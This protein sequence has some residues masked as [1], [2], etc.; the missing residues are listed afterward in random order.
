MDEDVF[1]DT[2]GLHQNT[3]FEDVKD[4]LSKVLNP[5]NA[6][7]VSLDDSMDEMAIGDYKKPEPKI[8][9]QPQTPKRDLLEK[10]PLKTSFTDPT[11]NLDAPDMKIDAEYK[12][13]Y[14]NSNIIDQ[15]QSSLLKQSVES[16]RGLSKFAKRGL[17]AL[18]ADEIASK[19]DVPKPLTQDE[20]DFIVGYSTKNRV[21]DKVDMQDIKNDWVNG[22]YATATLK[23]L[24]EMPSI[25]ADSSGEIAQL[26]NL[27]STALA[28]SARVSKYE[29]EYVKNN[30]GKLPDA[31]W[32]AEAVASQ[33]IILLAERFGI[34]KLAKTLKSTKP[35]TA[36]GV[37]GGIVGAGGF[38]GVQEY[39]ENV[40]EGYLTQKDGAKTLG[41]LATSDDAKFSAFLGTVMGGSMKGTAELGSVAYK[42]INS[43]NQAD[44]REKFV[45]AYTQDAYNRELL[46]GGIVSTVDDN[47]YVEFKKGIDAKVKKIQDEFR[48]L[49]I[50]HPEH[51]VPVEATENIAVQEMVVL[52]AKE[53]GLN[54]SDNNGLNVIDTGFKDL[55]DELYGDADALPEPKGFVDTPATDEIV[56]K[57]DEPLLAQ[58]EVVAPEIDIQRIKEL[59]SIPDDEMTI[60]EQF[61]LE[62]LKEDS[63]IA[64][65]QDTVSEIEAINPKEEYSFDEKI[66]ATGSIEDAV[67]VWNEIY[68]SDISQIDKQNYLDI[69]S[70][71][72]NWGKQFLKKI[73]Q[74]KKP[75]KKDVLG[76][77]A[78]AP[79]IEEA[80]APT[81]EPISKSEKIDDTNN[82]TNN[83]TIKMYLK[84]IE[85]NPDNATYQEH[86]A[87]EIAYYK[88]LEDK[89]KDEVDFS[90][91]K[92]DYDNTVQNHLLEKLDNARVKNKTVDSQ[93]YKPTQEEI[94]IVAAME[95]DIGMTIQLKKDGYTL[96][97][98][99]SNKDERALENTTNNIDN[100]PKAPTIEEAKAKALG[101]K[102]GA[103]STVQEQ[104][105]LN[106]KMYGDDET[107]LKEANARIFAKN[108]SDE[109]KIKNMSKA[110]IAELERE[111]F[112]NRY[113]ETE[114]SRA[115]DFLSTNTKQ[116]SAQQGS[117][118]F[119]GTQQQLFDTQG[120]EEYVVPQWAKPLVSDTVRYDDIITAVTDAKNGNPSDLSRRVMQRLHDDGFPHLD[121]EIKRYD[122]IVSRWDLNEMEEAELSALSDLLKEYNQ[123]DIDGR[124]ND[125][126][127]EEDTETRD[128]REAENVFGGVLQSEGDLQ[129]VSSDGKNQRGSQ[130]DGDRDVPQRGNDEVVTPELQEQAKVKQAVPE[131][132]YTI[133]QEAEMVFGMKP[134]KRLKK[135]TPVMQ[136]NTTEILR[137]GIDEAGVNYIETYKASGLPLRPSNGKITLRG[138]S[139]KLPTIE[140]PINSMSLREHLKDIVSARVYDKKIK[141]KST[142]GTYNKANTAIRL[143]NYGDVEVQAHE[144]AHYL[145]FHHNN[146]SG[147]E[148]NSEFKSVIDKHSDFLKTISYTSE[149]SVVLSE[150]FAEFVRLWIT[151]Y[152]TIA[153]LNP[154]LVNDFETQIAQNKAFYK[155]MLDYQESAHQFYFQGVEENLRAKS[156]GG[157]TRKAQKIRDKNNRSL[158]AWR[159]KNVDKNHSIKLAEIVLRG[160]I[161]NADESPYKQFQLIA[162]SRGSV[163]MALKY[164]V[165]KI[166]ENGDL[167]LDETVKGL[168]KIFEPFKGN[169]AY[170][171]K[172]E[173]YFKARRANELMARGKE[174]LISLQ[175]IEAGLEIGKNDAAIAKAF[176]EYQQHNSAMIEFYVQSNLLTREEAD[177]FL[178]AGKD[179]VPFHRI[180]ES[181]QTGEGVSAS[182]IGQRLTG[183]T[184]LIGNILENIYES[185]ATNIKD[186]AIARAKTQLYKMITEEKGAEFAVKVEPES[187]KFVAHSQQQAAKVAKIIKD[188]G[189]S[190]SKDG[191]MVEDIQADLQTIEE[192]LIANPAL[193][194]FW[195]QN[196]KPQSEN[197]YIDSAIIDGKREYF[198]VIDPMI[199][200]TLEQI[201]PI[202]LNGDGLVD[203]VIS[204]AMGYKNLNTTYITNNP[205]FYLKNA[206]IDTTSATFL[207]KNGFVPIVHT[208]VGM[209]H[210]VRKTKTY[211]NFMVSG[212]AYSTRRT[213]LG[214]FD[215]IQTSSRFNKGT[216]L[217]KDAKRVGETVYKLSA[218]EKIMQTVAYGA[219]VFEQGARIGEASLASK[220][221]KSN[222]EAAWQGREIS[223]DFSIRGADAKVATLLA[224]IP[225]AKASINS[226]DKLNRTMFEISG[227]QKLSNLLRFR[228]NNGDFQSQKLKFMLA[229]AGL[230]SL[231]LLLWSTNKDDERYKR[232]TADQKNMH[233]YIFWDKFGLEDVFGKRPLKLFKPYD[234]G[235]YFANLP[236]MIAQ[237]LNDNIKGSVEDKDEFMSRFIFALKQTGGVL[238]TP[239]IVR[240]FYEIATNSD[241]RDVPIES[242][243]LEGMQ[244]E[245]RAKPS[246]PTLYRKLG[247]KVLSPVQLQHLV[248]SITGLHGRMLDDALNTYYWDKEKHGE[249]P[250]RSGG[251]AAYLTKR[252]VGSEVES[253]SKYDKKFYDHFEKAMEAQGTLS[254]LKIQAEKGDEKSLAALYEF[255]ESKENLFYGE[256]RADILEAHQQ[257]RS[258]A[259]AIAVIT[260]PP[261]EELLEK[262]YT[263]KAKEKAI[264]ELIEQKH[265]LFKNVVLQVDKALK[266]N[267]GK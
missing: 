84:G 137:M 232:L 262:Y 19:I 139:I 205:L 114:V 154:E 120:S 61:E 197:G 96:V 8:E 91:T 142:L 213:S 9:E 4:G 248:N 207:S 148:K 39:S 24:K 210:F 234:I 64:V 68:N 94:N 164:G 52:N 28:I 90:N 25:L 193:L 179:Y 245:Y 146:P 162:G 36:V 235:N 35:K 141:G 16:A 189:M 206:V 174:N 30:D 165:P 208:L 198:E 118:G 237:E 194:T 218:I 115:Y 47:G 133:E 156:G 178:E 5:K 188:I 266:D 258:I 49:T 135:K 170:I 214:A 63:A 216:L 128:A 215:D 225:F 122:S 6:D 72:D 82:F 34:G 76:E 23:S 110:D 98:I 37:G 222:L 119:E 7:G 200:N 88:R 48:N 138:K 267:K 265:A 113:S 108:N 175:E 246:T 172:M 13:E 187:K 42:K 17:E 191:Q 89:Y 99:S 184:H 45:E 54:V 153:M 149:K 32:Y 40:S 157:L 167:T 92:S 177:R 125:R 132:S 144:M 143:K 73:D 254:N 85:K 227:E 77:Q 136:E 100:E 41:E 264:N 123:R 185:V 75:V 58:D 150:G 20:A 159:Q 116:T 27:P 38:E 71:S 29:D 70:D 12:P 228:N 81:Q 57:Q 192:H 59:E 250:F 173:D 247:N 111:D 260:R 67:K 46:G 3:I 134:A 155:K 199:A 229:G 65:K 56:V 131:D 79:T 66:K 217:S 180:K 74:D 209:Y 231:S 223:T 183:G 169:I 60:D 109:A 15:V 95:N 168:D 212:G 201:S 241:W 112:K 224:T 253:R 166:N 263:A 195:A 182:S 2:V 86:A 18:G 203:G 233:W 163:D 186:A 130:E 238:D 21:K 127:T 158:S 196:Q 243:R 87:R 244:K 239:G 50:N 53:S 43:E 221:G 181:V 219:D 51:E 97:P 256:V 140:D 176:E 22:D 171:K 230:A 259:D 220:K 257:A 251:V 202:T 261:N 151:N 80:N 240:P 226:I 107:A 55:Q 117:L 204:I 160:E 102:K 62:D 33:S 124:L 236:E 26:I 83:E 103:N 105:T 11:I 106:E 10:F 161:G 147:K 31:E 249:M 145:E 44:V 93:Y 126:R 78:Q 101:N 14:D 211:K 1:L 252:F 190:V 104:L 129:E 152:N 255:I 121:A 242:K 69:I